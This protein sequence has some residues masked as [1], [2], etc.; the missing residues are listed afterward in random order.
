MPISMFRTIMWLKK[1]KIR[2]SAT[3]QPEV[4]PTSFKA[5]EGL[6][7]KVPLSRSTHI[8]AG[9]VGKR[10]WRD[11]KSSFACVLKTTPKTKRRTNSSKR[12]K[13]TDRIAAAIPLSSVTTS[14]TARRSRAMRPSLVSRRS[15]T[16]RKIVSSLTACTSLLSTP[17]MNMTNG[18]IQTS[19]II[20]TTKAPSKPNQ[21][22]FKQS[23][24]RRNAQKRMTISSVKTRQNRCSIAVC[25]A[26]SAAILVLC[27]ASASTPIQ[28]EFVSTMIMEIRKKVLLLA[29]AAKQP[30]SL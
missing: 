10:S 20:K 28:T 21:K 9:T 23:R 25:S 19:P 30:E 15:R 16:V 27:G 26:F 5:T 1:M 24:F 29:I 8:V 18:S 22:S 2:K 11:S 7:R 3:S 6:S 4:A 17:A 12:V 13:N 14:G